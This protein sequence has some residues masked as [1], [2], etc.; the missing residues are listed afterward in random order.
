MS[1]DEILAIIFG[2]LMWSMIFYFQYK[3]KET[4]KLDYHKQEN[5]Q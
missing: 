5:N 1:A 3:I 2:V 4:E